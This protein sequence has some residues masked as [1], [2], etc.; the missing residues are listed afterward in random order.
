[1]F[2]T[3]TYLAAPSF[4]IGGYFMKL[5]AGLTQFRPSMPVLAF[6]SLVEASRPSSCEASKWP[7][8]TSLS[9]ASKP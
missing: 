2:I 6:S 4:S 9:W 8:R 5:S 7:S 3:L 1:M